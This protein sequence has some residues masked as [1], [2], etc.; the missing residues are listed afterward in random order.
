M[1]QVENL[2]S[3]LSTRSEMLPSTIGNGN[4]EPESFI[5]GKLG[6]TADVS[7][8]FNSPLKVLKAWIRKLAA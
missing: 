1:V 4:D 5:S 8:R 2:E 3:K 6:V 7:F